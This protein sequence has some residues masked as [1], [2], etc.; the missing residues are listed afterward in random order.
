SALD[1][2]ASYNAVDRASLYLV[3]P[4]RLAGHPA[5]PAGEYRSYGLSF[6]RE[7]LERAGPFDA[8][9]RSYEDTAIAERV[10]HLGVE[11]WFDPRV[12]IEHD[13]P[14][15]VRHLVRDQFSRGRRE[16]W[17][18]L[19]RLPSGRHRHRW[20]V[21]PGTRTLIVALRA[22]Y[23]LVKRVRATITAV[24]HGGTGSRRERSVLFLPMAL[25]LLAFQLGWA[26][27]QLR[28]TQSAN[29]SPPR[30][31]LPAPTGF[32]RWVT[33]DGERVAALTFDGV[34]PSPWAARILEILL[35][36]EVPAAFFVTGV[37]A[38]ERPDDVRG[39]AGAGHL[40]GTSGW[41]GTPFP[42]LSTEDLTDE[43]RRS[44]D[45][46]RELAGR[47]VRHARPPEGAYDWPVASTLASLGLD[48][49]LWTTHPA[50]PV[51]GARPEE[52]KRS[53]M[54]GLTPGAVLA[55]GVRRPEDAEHVVAALGPIIEGC[56]GRGYQ[57]VALGYVPP[58]GPDADGD[59]PPPP[60]S[61][62]VG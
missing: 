53:T 59:S 13:G 33:T 52:L 62:G 16:S 57:L 4:A 39:V 20:E 31:H 10:R 61:T 2:M 36:H 12:C 27:D 28:A 22:V 51:T 9:L 7:L 54:D 38:T 11:P 60:T 50:A 23:R 34:P 30:D 47:P 46:L 29:H 35:A 6:T 26:A 1:A 24:H 8:T 18:E 17:A 19:L 56:R 49:W 25:G 42:A 37:D 32:R 5:G 41:S 43:L 48:M 45:L 3:H 21:A 44:G 15:T 14:G 40:V 55:L 58:G